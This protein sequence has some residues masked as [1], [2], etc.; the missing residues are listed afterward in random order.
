MARHYSNG[1]NY[2]NID[3]VQ[4]DSLQFV[5]AKHGIAGYGLLVEL[6]RK[7]YMLEGY[8]C[9]WNEKN[10]YLFAKD[11]SVEVSFVLEVVETCFQEDLFSRVLYKNSGI[12]TGTGVQKRWLKIVTEAKRKLCKILPEYSLLEQTPEVSTKT[13]EEL[14]KT[15]EVLPQKKRKEKK[16]NEVKETVVAAASPSLPVV[17]GKDVKM[18]SKKATKQETPEPFWQQLV[19]VWF[20][21][22]KEKFGEEP[23]FSGQDPKVFK[24][25]IQRLKERAAKKNA[26]WNETTAPQRLQH[27]LKCAFEDTWICKN[28]LLKNLESQ[29]D[30]IIQNQNEKTKQAAAPK[31]QKP[32]GFNATLEYLYGRYCEGD[33]LDDLI[34][35]E[36]YDTMVG[37]SILPVGFMQQQEGASQDEK[38]RNAVK[39]FFKHQQEQ[40]AA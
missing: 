6:W 38:K 20:Q 7:I 1:I 12:L 33:L 40:H 39:S 2:F 3:C 30:K 34:L 37:R 35:P 29:F 15:P 18:K 11:C 22:G 10:I 9:E 16:V 36:Y 19:D 32:Q 8:Y 26:E 23:S 5:K 24:R 27:F 17:A 4:E 25:I 13:P 31:Q 21:F 28:F 14:P